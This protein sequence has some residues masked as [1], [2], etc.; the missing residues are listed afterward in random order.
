MERQLKSR[1]D[2]TGVKISEELKDRLKNLGKDGVG[3]RGK[4]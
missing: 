1:R 2:I 3:D 4:E